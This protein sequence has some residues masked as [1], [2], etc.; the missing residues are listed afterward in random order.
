MVNVDSAPQVVD[1]TEVEEHAVAAAPRRGVSMSALITALFGIGGF[2]L[3][4]GSLGDNSFLWHM[5]T[6]EF[7]GGG[8]VVAALDRAGGVEVELLAHGELVDHAVELADDECAPGLEL[9]QRERRLHER[10]PARVVV[11]VAHEHRRRAHEHPERQLEHRPPPVALLRT[12]EHDLDQL[13]VTDDHDRRRTEVHRERAAVRRGE[14][15]DRVD[16]GVEQ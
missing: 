6:G 2:A 7:A 9:A 13:A 10:S 3:G 4:A 11:A 1:D 12:G 16:G 14:R 8:D 5:R 15:L